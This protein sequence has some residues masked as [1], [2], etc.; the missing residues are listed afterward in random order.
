M[1]VA[2]IVHLAFITAALLVS[3][4]H[5][6]PPT[7]V[8]AEIGAFVIAAPAAPAP[9]PPAPARMRTLNPV[10]SSPH[11]AAPVEVPTKIEPETSVESLVAVGTVGGVE[12]GVPGGV[13]D[14]IV[15]TMLPGAVPRPALPPTPTL[16][17]VGG[18]IK[19][20]AL[21]TRVE[22]EY[23][24]LAREAHIEGL[25]ILE[26]TV[27]TTG[28]VEAVRVLRSGGPLD[29]AAVDAVKQWQYSPLTLNGQPTP[30]VV[31]VT[32]NFHFRG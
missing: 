17:R 31:T 10:K 8:P 6:A 19:A 9:P 21:V 27:D 26:A 5:L 11:L 25:V 20:P 24:L 1:T 13:I 4:Y 22:P 16:V 12:G 14:G 23:P 28:R 18:Q 2:G 30:F 15:G 7:P 3:L 32:L 29:E